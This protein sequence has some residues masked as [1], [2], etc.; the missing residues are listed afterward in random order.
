MP[1][2]ATQLAQFKE[3]LQALQ[4]ELR[5]VQAAA[6]AGEQPVAL[7]PTRVGRLTRMDALQVQAM[8]IESNRRRDIQL[9]RIAAALQRLDSQTYG[10]CA[11]CEEDI[12]PKRLHVDPTVF[13]CVACATRAERTL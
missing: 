12:D 11:T 6:R 8:T 9:Q 2:D 4:A 1:L 7:D 5:T 13:L 10:V 3:R